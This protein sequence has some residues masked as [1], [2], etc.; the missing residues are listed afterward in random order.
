MAR[1]WNQTKKRPTYVALI[2]LVSKC[3]RTADG[4]LIF[5]GSLRGSYSRISINRK[6]ISGHRFVYGLINGPIP[7]GLVVCHACDNRACIEPSHLWVG[8][9]QDNMADRDA[10]GRQAQGESVNTAKLSLRQRHLII[11]EY[12]TGKTTQ[13][14][15]AKK[16]C[17]TQ[18]NISRIIRVF[19]GCQ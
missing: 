12:K 15:L 9:S 2:D 11:E 16:Y 10:K 4:C 18:G 13:V 3:K 14:L 19:G 5:Q 17:V 7:K 8:T 1:G 6:S